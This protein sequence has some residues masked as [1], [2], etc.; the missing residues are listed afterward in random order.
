MI[1]T[2]TKP[3]ICD[4]DGCDFASGERGNLVR[5]RKS[6]TGQKDHICDFDGCSAAFTA[7]DKLKVHKPFIC[8]AESCGYA[9]NK[10]GN[11]PTPQVFSS[12]TKGSIY[13]KKEEAR[14]MKLLQKYE[15]DFKEQH[16]IDFKCLGPDR[17]GFVIFR[18]SYKK[19][20]IMI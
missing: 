7:G 8:D 15:F 5:H 10:S 12:Y 18:S 3:F 9:S 16:M 13:A 1:H 11:L 2:K 4:W 20:G 19:T 6:H 14:I 17:E